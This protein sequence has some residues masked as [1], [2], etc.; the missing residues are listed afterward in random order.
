MGV[1]IPEQAVILVLETFPD[2]TV[3]WVLDHAD[4]QV[5]TIAL[6]RRSA[7]VFVEHLLRELGGGAAEAGKDPFEALA[8]VLAPILRD[9][10]GLR[11]VHVVTSGDLARVPWPALL[12]RIRPG[13]L[14]V[15]QAPSLSWLSEAAPHRTLERELLLVG[16]PGEAEELPGTRREVDRIAAAYGRAT[17][18]FGDAAEPSAV[19]DSLR[20]ATVVHVSAHTLVAA[21]PRRSYIDLSTPRHRGRR[22]SQDALLKEDLSQVSLVVLASCQGSAGPAARSSA[23]DSLARALL[24]RGVGAVVASVSDVEDEA[25]A[26]FSVRLHSLLARGEPLGSAFQGALRAL[27]ADPSTAA[28][29]DVW[30]LW[31][32]LGPVSKEERHVGDRG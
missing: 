11:Q 14:G 21:D 20:A 27:A 22:L 13:A 26:A 10:H 4:L 3:A 16:A 24:R 7:R 30:V 19:L 25:A 9:R 8:G 5:H 32:R 6:D 29:A 31:E 23:P 18:L 28:S 1:R 2:R 12:R 17:V 15:T